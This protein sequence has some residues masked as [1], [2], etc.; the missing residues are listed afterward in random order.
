MAATNTV[1]RA[2]TAMRCFGVNFTPQLP[3]GCQKRL[4][5]PSEVPGRL[6]KRV[7]IVTRESVRRLP[8][9]FDGLECETHD[10]RGFRSKTACSRALASSLLSSSTRLRIAAPRSEERRVGKECR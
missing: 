5:R 4:V 7:P 9:L 2:N 6:E 1:V 3:F 10:L 8:I